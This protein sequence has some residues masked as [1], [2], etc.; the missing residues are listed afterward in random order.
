MKQ[1]TRA[2]NLTHS[3]AMDHLRRML[4]QNKDSYTAGCVQCVSVYADG[5]WQNALCMI[6]AYPSEGC[7]AKKVSCRYPR[8]H[9]LEEW[10]SPNDLVNALDQIQKGELKAGGESVSLGPNV[11]F[12]EWEFLP[13]DN[14]YSSLPGYLYCSNRGQPPAIPHHDPLLSY[15]LP[16]YPN[17]YLAMREWCGLTKFHG[18]SDARIG[19]IRVFLPE[20]RVRFKNLVVTDDR[21]CVSIDGSEIAGL[22]IKGG[23]ECQGGYKPFELSVTAGEMRIELRDQIEGFEVYLLGADGTLYDFHRETRFWALGQN[24]VLGSL[25]GTGTDPAAV[26]KALERGEGETVEFKVFVKQG[27]SKQNELVETAIAFANTKGGMILL[28]VNNHCIVEGVEKELGK[29]AHRQNRKFEE[30][31]NSYIGWLKQ[32]IGGKL[33]RTLTIEFL[34][35]TVEQ[36]VVVMIRVPEGDQKPYANIQA[37]TIYI[38]R[39]ANNV[40]PHPDLELPQ[41]L[42]RSQELGP[43]Q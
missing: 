4:E 33:N 13:S 14:E 11:Q 3:Q 28:G 1:W 34:S 22:K 12:N 20:C 36:H 23:W 9:L 29:E 19:T 16:F 26:Q 39:G 17:P 38:R 7:P 40:V 35:V 41:L 30:E 27:D 24:R 37:N 2:Y 25:P 18:E 6:R 42:A 8:V 21:L 31:L 10:L 43:M 5:T 32:A 15:D